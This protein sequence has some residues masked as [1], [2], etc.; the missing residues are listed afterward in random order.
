MPQAL[1]QSENGDPVE[2]PML[3]GSVLSGNQQASPGERSGCPLGHLRGASGTR[4]LPLEG[5][6]LAT[7]APE[8]LAGIR[9]SRERDYNEAGATEFQ[10]SKGRTGAQFN[11]AG[12]SRNIR[13]CPR[14]GSQRVRRSYTAERTGIGTHPPT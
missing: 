4:R 9:S 3:P 7:A 14:S 10:W 11:A 5:V 8:A 13:T 12:R 2:K 1:V 6:R